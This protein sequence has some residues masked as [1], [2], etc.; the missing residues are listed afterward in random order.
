MLKN[1]RPVAIGFEEL[2]TTRLPPKK[3]LAGPGLLQRELVM[4]YA[5]RGTGKTWVA[6]QLAVSVAS[7]APFIGWEVPEPLPVLYVDGEMA[8]EDMQERMRILAEGL[9]PEQRALAA[10]NF[11][12]LSHARFD[13]DFPNLGGKDGTGRAIVQ[14]HA[15]P[16]ALIILDNKSALIRSDQS[17]NEAGSWQITKAW[18]NQ[19][20]ARGFTVWIVNH[21]GKPDKDTGKFNGP[22]GS[23]SQEDNLD[24]SIA[25]V[26]TPSMPRD[27]LVWQFDKFRSKAIAQADMKFEVVIGLDRLS[28]C[29]DDEERKARVLELH[30]Q[31]VPQRQIKETIQAAGG[32]IGEHTISRYI[33]EAKT[34]EYNAEAAAR[35]EMIG[36]DY[37]ERCSTAPAAPKRGRSG[38]QTGNTGQRP[39]SS[40]AQ[41]RLA[42]RTA[43]RLFEEPSNTP[44][45]PDPMPNR[46]AA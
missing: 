12:L 15:K 31:G 40:E 6:L 9:T 1:D 8:L 32:K 34:A 2:L 27:R 11:T 4:L 10:Q 30:R 20:R 37:A 28:R 39:A 41:S 45:S 16:G 17:E 42:T 13:G 24:K 14:R 3:P 18:L 33:G 26:R 22:R 21:T 19:L 43:D 7:G 36:A 25:L 38:Q 44:A 35:S 5:Y 46:E 29:M 23:S